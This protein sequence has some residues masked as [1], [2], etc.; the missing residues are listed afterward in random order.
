VSY[1]PVEGA[2][3]RHG[4]RRASALWAVLLAA[5]ALGLAASADTPP[6]E[7]DP[8][9]PLVTNVWVDVPLSQ[10]V[11]DISIETGTTITVDPSVAD[12]L[13]SLQVRDAPVEDCLEKVTAA[14][15][16]AVRRLAEGFYVLGTGKPDSPSFDRVVECRRI[17]LKYITDRHLRSSLPTSLAPYVASGERKTEVLVVAPP[18]KLKRI[19]EIADLLDVPPDQ[20]VLEVLVI[21]L[22]EEAARQLGIDWEW[23][24]R[25]TTVSLEES[26]DTFT[27]IFRHTS[28][29]ENEFR[30]LM[31]TL[32][33][34]V[35]TGQ[36]SIRS[37]PRVATL[38]GE[39]ATIEVALEEYFNIITDIGALVRTELQVV[40]SGVLLRMTP[41]IG[42]NGDISVTVS[43]EV[44]DV[45]TRR[46]G[47][48]TQ[49]GEGD[50]L[51]VIR[52]RRAETKVRVKEG[53]AIVI[54]GLVESQQR[55]EE[56]RV[57]IL[58]SIPLLGA[59]FRSTQTVSIEREVMILITPRIM[60]PGRT[61]LAARHR[62]INVEQELA[63][64]REDN[65]P[66]RPG[67]EGVTEPQ[68]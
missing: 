46:G 10:L 22:S 26:I 9:R 4:L 19:L 67:D 48:T 32:R 53:D 54:G 68:K 16:L 37:R 43:T 27:G 60:V 35:R 30:T 50:T 62:F 57:P 44:S 13:V 33:M 58:G 39:Q 66:P 38:N 45:A 56:K 21:E 11:R 36:A 34:L 25:D 14:Q 7:P 42:D 6:P 61:P 51:P 2:S 3:A 29:P 63:Q 52:R 65:A 1:S 28:V 49:A 5:M 41:Q 31:V 15:G 59:L 47:I 20:V 23:S 64:L 17:C 55:D 8:P 24:G 40:K 12:Q 18:E